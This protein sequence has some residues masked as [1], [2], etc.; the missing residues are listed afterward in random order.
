M[1]QPVELRPGGGVEKEHRASLLAVDGE[2]A[3]AV[4]GLLFG[5]GQGHG[6]ATH[7]GREPRAPLR[8]RP[9]NLYPGAVSQRVSM[10]LKA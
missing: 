5:I 1:C 3:F 2:M 10:S 8:K 9:T 6:R 4:A 7:P